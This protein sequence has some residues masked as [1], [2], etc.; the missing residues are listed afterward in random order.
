[1]PRPTG[2][3]TLVLHAPPCMLTLFSGFALWQTSQTPPRRKADQLPDK[4][5]IAQGPRSGQSCGAALFSCCVF[6][7]L[8]LV[9]SDLS[10]H[11]V[12][13][14]YELFADMM[15]EWGSPA[16]CVARVWARPTSSTRWAIMPDGTPRRPVSTS[17]SSFMQHNGFRCLQRHV[18]IAWPGMLRHLKR[19]RQLGRSR[20]VC[21]SQQSSRTRRLKALACSSPSYAAAVASRVK[22]ALSEV[23]IAS[24]LA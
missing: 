17:A 19:A 14:N 7:C 5:A 6:V 4:F 1:M 9:R 15:S 13:S 23:A 20:C 24:C 21:C 8:A 22:E 18:A 3:P 12:H 10:R 16:L 11:T 2:L